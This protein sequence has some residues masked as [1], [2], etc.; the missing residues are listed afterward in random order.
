MSEDLDPTYSEEDVEQILRLAVSRGSA[1]GRVSRDQLMQSAT[2]L[3]VSPEALASA[4]RAWHEQKLVN[5]ERNEFEGE[6]RRNF[7]S[8]VTTYIVINAFLFCI[9]LATSPGEWW[10]IFP[11]LGWG[12]GMVFHAVNTFVRSSAGHQDEFESWQRRKHRKLA[13]QANFGGIKA[14]LFVGTNPHEG[15]QVSELIEQSVRTQ[16]AQD[17]LA[18]QSRT[19]RDLQD[20]GGLSADEAR[21]ALQY[22]SQS[23]P[24]RIQG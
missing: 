22:W 5:A 7:W 17:S 1:A 6:L 12:I 18:R 3:G 2:E 15:D 13:R 19:L 4:E 21:E 8:H 16:L 10:F 23:N 11:L 20:V 24:G 14:G 9:N